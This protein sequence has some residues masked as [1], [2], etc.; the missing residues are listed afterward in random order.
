MR[1]HVVVPAI[2]SG[3]VAGVHGPRVRRG[4]DALQPLDFGD[5]VFNVHSL[6]YLTHEPPRQMLPWIR[7]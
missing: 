7:Y 2:S 6:Q 1:L 5:G 3:E 4:E